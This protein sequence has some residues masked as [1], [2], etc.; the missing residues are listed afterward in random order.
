MA[1]YKSTFVQP[2]FRSEIQAGVRREKAV[3]R[4]PVQTQPPGI[5]FPVIGVSSA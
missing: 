4:K 1:W 2:V 3:K 5:T